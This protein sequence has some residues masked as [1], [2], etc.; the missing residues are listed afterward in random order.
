MH[1]PR[2]PN[3]TQCY[4]CKTRT[5]KRGGDSTTKKLLQI[6]KGTEA[7]HT[8]LRHQK[9]LPAIKKKEG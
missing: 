9:Y 1:L 5:I 3:Y 4:P 2:A 6:A 8:H 7:K